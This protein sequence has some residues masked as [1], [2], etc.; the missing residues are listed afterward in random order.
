M[1]RAYFCTS[2]GPSRRDVFWQSGKYNVVYGN[3]RDG[4]TA[5]NEQSEV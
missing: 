4:G 5:S 2:T 1:A 3:L